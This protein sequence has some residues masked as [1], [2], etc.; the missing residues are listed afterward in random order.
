MKVPIF[1]QKTLKVMPTLEIIFASISVLI[2][3]LG[4]VWGY[5]C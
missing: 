3:V 2:A 4:A 5:K 1:A